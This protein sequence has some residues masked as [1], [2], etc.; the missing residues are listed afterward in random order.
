MNI[1]LFH[2]LKQRFINYEK[3]KQTMGVSAVAFHRGQG[4]KMLIAPKSL[5]ICHQKQVY[6]CSYFKKYY[7]NHNVS[8]TSM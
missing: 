6:I 3:K 2:A 1:H 7:F 5:L 4:L 8:E